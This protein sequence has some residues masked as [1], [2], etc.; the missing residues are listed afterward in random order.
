[1]NQR[2]T[3]EDDV[4]RYTLFFYK[5]YFNLLRKKSKIITNILGTILCDIKKSKAG[6]GHFTH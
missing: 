3:R 4:N 6:R 5:K 2:K 1:M